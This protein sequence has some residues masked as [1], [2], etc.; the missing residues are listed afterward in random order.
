MATTRRGFLLA[1][2]GAAAAPLLS[3]LTWARGLEGAAT[4]RALLVVEL[5]GGND[6]LNTVVP[7]ADPLY[8]RARPSLRIGADGVRKIGDGVGLRMEL[9]A[10]KARFDRGQLAIVQGVGYPGPDRSHFRSTDIWHAASLEPERAR[11]GWIGRTWEC[12]SSGRR[13]PIGPGLPALMVG[14]AKVPLALVGERSSALQVGDVGR[15]RVP[16]GPK[17]AS[18]EERRQSLARLATTTTAAEHS[19]GGALALLK[20]AARDAQASAAKVEEAVAK[21]RSAT[22]WPDTR[23]ARELELVAQLIAGGFEC[24]AYFVRQEGY[25]THAF[26]ADAH[27]LL[28]AELDGALGAFLADVEAARALDRVAV[29]VYSEFGRRVKE[30]GSKG[31]DH[32]AAAPLLVLGGAVKGGLVGHAPS[33]A[34]ADLDGG[35]DGD[36]V[37][38]IDFRRVYATLLQEWFGVAPKRV[39]GADFEKLPLFA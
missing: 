38:S 15:F 4:G 24:A 16:V 35:E 39:L 19:G 10:L 36:L 18:V 23:L 30:N 5:G 9:A 20:D 6:G 26:Q 28:L 21:G 11:T 14:T 31:T 22:T 29:L 7:F 17:D 37:H 25:D 1:G 27:A 8:V 33:L 3:R 12:E 13:A 34:P 32:G 2:L